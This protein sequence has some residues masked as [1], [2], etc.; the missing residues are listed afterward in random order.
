MSHIEPGLRITQHAHTTFAALTLLNVLT[1]LTA[2][3][4]RGIFA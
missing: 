2:E 1:A 3:L 4:A